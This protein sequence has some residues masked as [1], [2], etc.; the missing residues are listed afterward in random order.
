MVAHRFV[1]SWLRRAPEDGWS[2]T[3][4]GDEPYLPYD[5]VHL[6]EHVGGRTV[7]D[8]AMAPAVWDDPR[9]VLRTGDAVAAVDRE[10]RTV[11]T[12]SGS[13]HP[14][15]TLVLATGSWAWTPRAEGT[16]LP[17]VFSYRT[18][19][20]L[21]GLMAWVRDRGAA[22]GRSVRGVVVGG[23]VLGLEAAAALQTL[24]AQAAVVEFADRLMAVQLDAGGGEALRV[25]VDD[26]G[27]EVR[28]GAAAQRLVAGP[29]GAV[30]R[31]ELST[32]DVLDADV[33]VFST[34]VRPRDRLARESGLAVGE[35][36]GVVVGPTC[37]TSDPAVWAIGECAS[38][39]G[40]CAGLVA[41]GNAMADVV[42][43]RLL[44]GT[45]VHSRSAEGTKLK[46]VGIDAA[47]F[48]DVLGLTPGALE[49]T[50]ADPVA[51]TYKKLVV[52]DDARTLLGGVFVGDIDLYSRLRPLLGRPL[53]ADPAAF[54]TP[55][56]AG[57]APQTELPDDVVV[58]S[59]ANVTAGTI[60]GA[61]SEHGC[62][63]VGEVKACTKAGTVCGSCVPLV[64]TLVNTALEKAG[65]EVSR[66]MCEHFAMPRAELL[67]LVRQDGLRTFSE[68]VA[69]HG[70]GR[71]CAVCK[72]V[73]ASI[74]SVLG[75]GHVLQPDQSSLQDTND[76]VLANLQKDGTYSVVPRVPA[77]EITP[78]KLAVLAQV[79]QDFGLYTRITGAQRIGLFGA[80]LD[81]L[82]TIWRRLVDAGF[83]SG[84]AYGKSLRAVKSCIGSAWCRFGVQDSVS[85]ATRLELRYRGLRSPHKFKV[86]VSGCARE[87]AEARGK[88]VGVIATE[89]G[90]NVYVGGN[91][92]FTP[93]HAELL[94]E[95]L[96]DERVV[97]V[98]DRFLAL[99]IRS[100]DRLQR[101]A[102]W[103]AGFEGGIAE[104]R[105]V[106][107][108]DSRGLGAEL[109]AEIAR[110]VDA[111]VDEWRATLED[112]E[113]LRH[114]VAF[115]NAPDQHD[116]DLSYTSLRGQVRPARTGDVQHH[117]PR[118][119]RT[120]EVV[121]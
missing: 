8:L 14:Y 79:A 96:D 56:G 52:S 4:L 44:G 69:K 54:L 9:V 81:Q 89:K 76:H 105:R 24:G 102:P 118:V 77:G 78:E 3:V 98:V 120:L 63:S 51:K 22:L 5:R 65:V 107:V 28:T 27:M 33:V 64:T 108:E 41:P 71:G 20:D 74:L 119:A 13:V 46:G 70:T 85:M 31:A 80:R 30:A 49:V 29:D 73:V 19:D 90:W 43:D 40:E 37:R 32:G 84:Q 6:S 106:V 42:V 60:R 50:F 17:G 86:G 110:H 82:P 23:G 66:A 59:C 72:P 114:F 12:A 21:R 47:S 62:T 121:P 34:G 25:L 68:V 36:G 115:V 111:Y 55:E 92:G 39:E 35:R 2:L 1:E 112:P 16:D 95:D 94:A 113:K 61:V 99:Y 97:Q 26:L 87:C 57:G 116:P 11:R 38:F 48:G 75:V 15:D 117:D 67:A 100:A 83:E 104:L 45:A 88:D 58:C 53:G 93:R 109:E 103:V 91:G 7:E 101:T 10:A 18:L